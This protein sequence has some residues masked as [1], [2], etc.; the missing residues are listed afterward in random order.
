MAAAR[1]ETC[2]RSNIARL[3]AFSVIRGDQRQ[4]LNRPGVI[5]ANSPDFF[6]VAEPPGCL[7]FLYIVASA[8]PVLAA[9]IQEE[10]M[11]DFH[12]HRDR[13]DPVADRGHSCLAT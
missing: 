4:L 8:F 5:P 13:F 3:I 1:V 6:P 12:N 7:R 2:C 11:S 9:R 10:H